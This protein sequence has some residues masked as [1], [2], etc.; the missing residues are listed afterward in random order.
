MSA[1]RAGS[2]IWRAIQTAI[3]DHFAH[4]CRAML[5]HSFALGHAL[6]AALRQRLALLRVEPLEQICRSL[7]A[8]LQNTQRVRIPQVLVSDCL[9]HGEQ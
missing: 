5:C 8:A 3:G 7:A 4:R 2:G 1:H 9:D 6:A